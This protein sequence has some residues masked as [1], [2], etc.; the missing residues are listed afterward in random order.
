MIVV[1][2][3]FGHEICM[4]LFHLDKP[5]QLEVKQTL[6]RNCNQTNNVLSL[7]SLTDSRKINADMIDPRPTQTGCK[8]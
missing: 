4:L 8:D 5:A 7:A 1:S 3:N 2:L 6:F